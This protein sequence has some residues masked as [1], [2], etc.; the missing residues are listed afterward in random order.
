MGANVSIDYLRPEPAEIK[1]GELWA[2][3]YGLVNNGD[4]T[5]EYLQ[6]D[7]SLTG[8]D[9]S[10][11][12]HWGTSLSDIAPGGRADLR[13]LANDSLHNDGTFTVQVS[14]RDSHTEFG[15]QDTTFHVTTPPPEP[16]HAAGAANVTIDAAD[17]TLHP[18]ALGS[19]FTLDYSLTNSGDGATVNLQLD[20]ELY[21][22]NSSE[23]YGNY[24][25]SAPNEV[26]PGTTVNWAYLFPESLNNEGYFTARVK[27]SDTFADYGYHDVVFQVAQAG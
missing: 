8:P 18:V 22:P 24:G 16:V 23:L 19:G 25:A 3:D 2:V 14:F 9:G 12:G 27:F 11:F 21:G 1:T 7:V 13:Y 4:A 10:S 15:S 5:T 17:V 6:I 26:P 20:L